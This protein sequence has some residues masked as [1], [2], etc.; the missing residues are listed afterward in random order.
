MFKIQPL[1]K[2]FFKKSTFRGPLCDKSMSGTPESMTKKGGS[3][4]NK[5]YKGGNGAQQ[6]GNAGGEGQGGYGYV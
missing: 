1:Y 6:Q 2:K 4:S 3:T 5:H